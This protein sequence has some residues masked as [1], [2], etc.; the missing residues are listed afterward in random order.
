MKLLTLLILLVSLSSAQT[1]N[2]SNMAFVLPSA[3][4]FTLT[5]VSASSGDTIWFVFSTN[6]SDCLSSTWTLSDSGGNTYTQIGTNETRTFTCTAS[7]YAKN[8]TGFSGNI[9]IDPSVGFSSAILRYVS[10]SGVDHTAPL[11]SNVQTVD[12]TT[13]C[14]ATAIT[15]TG[16]EIIVTGVMNYYQ[17]GTYT[18]NNSFTIPTSGTIT[19]TAGAGAIAYR[20]VTAGAYTPS[21]GVSGGGGVY[22]TVMAAS[23]KQ[24]TPSTGVKRRFIGIG[25]SLI[26]SPAMMLDGFL[27]F[28]RSV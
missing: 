22:C 3:S 10:V 14:D 7:F 13:P 23:F 25:A 24:G 9:V 12:D 16:S 28:M 15:A 17:S 27:R 26:W 19:T 1:Y 18:A 11:A 5:G 2:S 4:T 21:F 6:N 8:V 20:A